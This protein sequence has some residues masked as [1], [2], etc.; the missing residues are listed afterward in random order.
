MLPVNNS[1]PSLMQQMLLK[2]QDLNEGSLFSQL[3]VSRGVGSLGVAGASLVDAIGQIIL[4]ALCALTA[5]YQFSQ[6][7]TPWNKRFNPL[8]PFNFKN[9]TGR[10]TGIHTWRHLQRGSRHLVIA[11]IAPGLGLLA[12]SELLIPAVKSLGFKVESKGTRL[13]RIKAVVSQ[14]LSNKRLALIGLTGLAIAGAAYMHGVL[15]VNEVEAVI[16]RM[17][18]HDYVTGAVVCVM[19]GIVTGMAFNKLSHVIEYALNRAFYDPK[20]AAK[21]LEGKIIVQ[22]PWQQ[23]R[24]YYLQNTVLAGS[25]AAMAATT[26]K[27]LIFAGYPAAMATPLLVNS[28]GSPIL[29][30]LVNMKIC[31]TLG[32]PGGR[33]IEIT[34]ETAKKNDIDPAAIEKIQWKKRVY[35]SFGYA[36]SLYPG[37]D[38]DEGYH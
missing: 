4:G 10:D 23:N 20:T 8:C 3:V 37:T 19:G 38:S 18:A 12:P 9:E 27:Y 14:A 35:S 15:P 26:V 28:V 21:T 25:V 31:E 6:H 1:P 7:A 5:A 22:M 36:P 33:W 16:P 13:K 24:Y 11:L 29:C 32:R 30:G 17:K 34:N 2:T